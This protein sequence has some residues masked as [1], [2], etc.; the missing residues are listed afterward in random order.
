MHWYL[1]LPLGMRLSLAC[2][3]VSA[4]LVIFFV[5]LATATSPRSE[6]LEQSGN[7]I[8]GQLAQGA[9]EHLVD[10]DRLALQGLL[11]ELT[12]QPLIAYAS[13]AD[14]QQQMIVESGVLDARAGAAQRFSAPLVFHGVELGTADIVLA[15]GAPPP[16]S[17][18][19]VLFL[20]VLVFSLVLLFVVL[21]LKALDQAL[22]RMSSTL[23]S[24]LP[25]TCP[26]EPV[27]SV[28]DLQ[29]VCEAMQKLVPLPG[30]ESA[31]RRAVL[32]ISLPQL[33]E[34]TLGAAPLK[35]REDLLH[36]AAD[37]WHGSLREC[38]DGWQLIF[39]T[40]CETAQRALACAHFL[41]V[42][43]DEAVEQALAIQTE[44]H[45]AANDNP[46][47]RNMHWQRLCEEARL[48]ADKPGEVC[49]TRQTLCE[50]GIADQVTVEQDESGN[51]RVTGF[52]EQIE[53][54]VAGV[55]PMDEKPVL[56]A[57]S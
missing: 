48:L 52:G 22:Q 39:T 27:K 53:H 50:E 31:A 56:R 51:Y 37:H 21:R 41:Q 6:L 45:A 57:V 17:P 5:S 10:E 20:G 44:G 24:L 12:R 4:L 54:R 14:N 36:Q 23:G 1:S 40:G 3:A 11:L 34:D 9:A 15:N 26:R 13:I 19:L 46:S 42:N 35:R 18:V 49:I 38:V 16:M 32:A 2:A 33:T 28:A 43:G 25:D 29:G 7:I 30:P 55:L 47:L 8:A